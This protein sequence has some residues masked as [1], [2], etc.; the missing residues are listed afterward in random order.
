MGR[1]YGQ[2]HALDAGVIVGVSAGNVFR[3]VDF[4]L[5]RGGTIRGRVLD[6]F[7]T[8]LALIEVEALRGSFAG[9][10]ASFLRIKSAPCSASGT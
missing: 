3:N 5:R 6:A 9:A 8:P 2:R 4:S 7:G 10:S 1:R